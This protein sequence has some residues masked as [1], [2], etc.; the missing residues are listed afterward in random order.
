VLSK[1]L[2]YLSSD[3]LCAWLWQGGKLCGGT[4]F[5]PDRAGVDDFMDYLDQHRAM[6]VYL[7]ADLI[8]EDFQRVNMPH[9]SGRAGRQLLQRKLLQQYRETPFR[10][11]EIQ[12][13]EAGGRRDDIALLSALTNPASVLPW[14]EAM[15][16]LRI[17]LAGLYSTTMLSGELARKLALRAPDLLLVTQQS[18]GWRQSYFQNGKLKFSRLTPAI[19]R[20]GQPVD[21]GAEAGKTR[22]FL[23][24]VRL[25][26]RGTVLETAIIAPAAQM[27]Q[28]EQQCEDGGEAV[29]RFITLES[30]ANKLGLKTEG[31][32]ASEQAARLSEPLML[33]LLA[34]LAP[35]SHYAIGAAR[36]YYQLW[37]TRLT[38][39]VCSA[40][41]AACSVLWVGCNL[42]QY[43]QASSDTARLSGETAMYDQRYRAVMASMPPQVASTA[44]MRA[45]VNVERMLAMQAPSPYNMVFMVSEALEQVPQIRLLN[46]DWK[47]D[48]PGAA[49][50]DNGADDAAVAPMSSLLAG[51]PSRPP[52]ALR[53]EAEIITDL[54]DYRKAVASMNQFAQQLARHPR[55]TVEIDKPP[56]DTR[57][58]VK[59]SGKAGPQSVDTRA[60][61]SLNLVW[62]P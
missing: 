41:L 17:P 44:N 12:D 38:L 23:N 52:Q 26:A 13:R 53:V 32:L 30:A 9:V 2:L 45:A 56:L 36:R 40:G 42:W 25:L 62:K 5:A 3:G 55:L 27:P 48:L 34:K 7:L 43:Q 50:K 24:S 60:K 46:L 10:H 37:R 51:I 58:S 61:F 35:A 20:D 57:S 28:L 8:E 21:V 11:I 14:I 19:N 39:Y 59:L 22:Q 29:F 15:E 6:P 49:V 33:C 31:G 16:Q 1:H 54:D 18:A 47:V 4:R